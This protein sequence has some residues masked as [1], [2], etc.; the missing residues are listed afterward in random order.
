VRVAS[1]AAGAGKQCAPAAP[2]RPRFPRPKDFVA[3]M[4]GLRFC[5]APQLNR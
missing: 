1:V 4:R 2:V 3:L 5:A